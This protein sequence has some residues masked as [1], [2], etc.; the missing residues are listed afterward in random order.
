MNGRC[1][2]QHK[3]QMYFRCTEKN[4]GKKDDRKYVVEQAYQTEYYT[5]NEYPTSVSNVYNQQQQDCKPLSQHLL[6][7]APPPHDHIYLS[8]WIEL[9]ISFHT[10]LVY[11]GRT[12]TNDDSILPPKHITEKFKM[13]ICSI[14]SP[15]LTKLSIYL[16]HSHTI[17]HHVILYYFGR[18][19]QGASANKSKAV[20]FYWINISVILYSVARH[21]AYRCCHISIWLV[22]ADTI[23]FRF[24]LG[25]IT[26]SKTKEMKTTTATK[27]NTHLG[28]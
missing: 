6:L 2:K 26:S 7:S 19:W 14:C 21:R 16:A 28:F 24:F 18:H 9:F 17:L 20:N 15:Y 12:T 3:S 5:T 27:K 8:V 13:S 25:L 23:S 1:I 11:S 22:C 10:Q 4:R